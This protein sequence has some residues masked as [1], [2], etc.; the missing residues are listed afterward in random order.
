MRVFEFTAI[1]SLFAEMRG[2]SGKCKMFMHWLSDLNAVARL[3]A[4][5][6]ISD[7]GVACLVVEFD[8]FVRFIACSSFS[9]CNERACPYSSFY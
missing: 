8:R 9:C 3:L 1:S 2:G 6:Y 5:V 4:T 7:A